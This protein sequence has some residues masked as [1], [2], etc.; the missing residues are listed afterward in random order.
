MFCVRRATVC[1][2][3]WFCMCVPWHLFIFASKLP[4]ATIHMLIFRFKQEESA[5][6]W[7][8]EPL[9]TLLPGTTYFALNG[10]RHFQLWT[11]G[12]ER[13]VFLKEITILNYYYYLQHWNNQQ[14][15]WNAGRIRWNAVC[16]DIKTVWIYK[17]WISFNTW[18]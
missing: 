6:S 8:K 2:C 1:V 11:K 3:T 5:V 4:I 7:D 12:V 10:Y 17:L 15:I 14:I 13:Q 9:S 16:E 18:S